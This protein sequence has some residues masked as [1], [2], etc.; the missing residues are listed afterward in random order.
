[1]SRSA[2]VM[3]CRICLPPTVVVGSGADRHAA[4][5]TGRGD[6]VP[7][8]PGTW[9]C[10]WGVDSR[11]RLGLGQRYV[12]V[13]VAGHDGGRQPAGCR[14]RL[15]SA[16]DSSPACSGM[17]CCGGGTFRSYSP[18]P[19]PDCLNSRLVFWWDPAG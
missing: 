5:P 7:V 8:G 10:E 19:A 1:M 15:A 3:V 13:G 16:V 18:C 2:S 14:E 11:A 4:P 9:W 17:P 6:N 12:V